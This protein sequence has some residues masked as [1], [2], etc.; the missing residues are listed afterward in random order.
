MGD[1][2]QRSITAAQDIAATTPKRVYPNEHKGAATE[3]AT[4]L[5][6]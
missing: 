3:A 2:S 6:S 1:R 4:P 5:C